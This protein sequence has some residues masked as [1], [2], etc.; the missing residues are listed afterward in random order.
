[1]AEGSAPA[2]SGLPA[3]ESCARPAGAGSV[4]ADGPPAVDPSSAGGGVL[5]PVSPLP[6]LGGLVSAGVAPPGT[7]G[8][9]PSPASSAPAAC[10]SCCWRSCSS[11]ASITP[12]LCRAA[13]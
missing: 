6:L 1:P 9:A 11:R 13:V 3:A 5:A 10:C 4:A 12:R 8:V 7:S 2:A